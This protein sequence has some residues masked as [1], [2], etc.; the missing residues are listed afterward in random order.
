MQLPAFVIAY[1][2]SNYNF[3]P[4]LVG[5]PHRIRKVR[6]ILEALLVDRGDAIWHAP[7]SHIIGVAQ[8]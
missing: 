3:H 1:S 5:Q 8:A 2:D 4:C 6:E 7:P